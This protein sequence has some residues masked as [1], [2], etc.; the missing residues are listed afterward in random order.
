M[1][2]YNHRDMKTPATTVRNTMILLA[3]IACAASIVFSAC[4]LSPSLDN[5]SETPAVLSDTVFSAYA[6]I[7]SNANG[8]LDASDLPLPGAQFTAA[9]FGDVTDTKG[10]AMILIPGDWDKPVTARMA[11]PKGSNYTIIGPDEQ[12]LQNGKTNQIKFLFTSATQSDTPADSPQP[13]STLQVDLVYCTTADGVDLTMDLYQ[14][15]IGTGPFP[16]IVYVHGG[17]WT[18]GD[19]SDGVGLIFKQ[20]MTRRGYIFVSINYR[21]APKY[22][23]PAQIEDVKCAIRHLRANSQKYNLDPDRVG[24][25]GGSAGGHLVALLGASTNQEGWDV[26]QDIDQSSR[27]Q[28]V[29]DLYGPADLVKMFS[30]SNRPDM[31]Q[32]FKAAPNAEPDLVS[33]SPV[34]Y[35]TPDDPPFLILHGDQDQVVPLVQSQIL[36]ERLK[37]NGIASEL[38]VVKNAGHSFEPVS[39]K[40][41]PSIRELLAH[42]GDFFDRYLK[43]PA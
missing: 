38:I 39:G 13:G 34:N 40:I 41:K 8:V 24:G 36:Y 18:S 2:E 42:V 32:V 33:Y 19:K 3:S 23:F 21:L 17:G 30:E 16:V 1:C 11:P 43:Y 20:E 35:I 25:L 31:L 7:D 28:A 10:F 26:G 14:P 4:G 5:P 37:E 29:V 6:F 9:G 22:T 27:I 15:K 12:I